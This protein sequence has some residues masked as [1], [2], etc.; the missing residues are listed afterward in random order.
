MPIQFRPE[1][2]Q[3]Q[4]TR[5]NGKVLLLTGWPSWIT[6]LLTAG[7]MV[8]LLAFLV[9][10]SFTRRI[11]VSGE[12]TTEPHTINLFAP[13]QGVI[14]Q[15]LVA[16]GQR[17]AAGTPLYQLNVSQVTPS[18]NVTTTS[19]AAIQKQ[20][21]NLDAIISQL[22]SNK[23]ETLVNLQQQLTQY[24]QEQPAL[25]A[26]VA[27]ALEG[28]HAMQRSR[29]AYANALHKGL[30]TSDQMNNQSYL[31][32]QQQ[33]V[34]QNLNSQAIQQALQISNLRSELVTKAAEFD[35]QISQSRYQRDDLARQ[36]AET[37]AKG[38]RLITAPTSGIVSSLSVTPG[39]MV[40][41]GDSLIQLVPATSYTFRLIAWLP[42]DSRPYVKP[43]EVINIRYAAFPFEKYGQ[44]P[45]RIISVS[46]APVSAREL[47]GYVSAPRGTDG[48][49]SGS[50]Y[51][52]TVAL[53]EASMNW[54]GR[55]LALSSGMQAQVSLFLEKRPLY[56]WMLSP[57]YSLKKSITGPVNE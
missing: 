9:F 7:F 25:Q 52:A 18:G 40:N 42:D 1:V 49:V 16:N 37:D 45:G 24:E 30:I 54:H 41:A 57:Y 4:Q 34:Y 56:Q 11:N 43:G 33:S 38:S 3:H 55:S 20:Q 31:Y 46:S 5:W 47:E 12:V 6:V 10:A 51:K 28:L 48:T 36:M 17:V 22:Q 23:R 19:L 32:Y 35:N 14:S 50:W 29:N 13:E 27:S 44:F 39:Q 21:Q 2:I 53:D 26:M 15:L 8:A